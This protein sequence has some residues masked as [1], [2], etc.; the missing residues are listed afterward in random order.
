MTTTFAERL[1]HAMNE[2]H[3]SQSEL[4]SKTGISKASIS[5][6]LSGKNQ[7][8]EEKILLMADVLKA[9]PDFLMGKDVPPMLPHISVDKIG[10]R[11]AARCLGKSEQFIRIGLQRGI[12]PFGNA[13]PG[14]GKH[15]NYYINPAKF[16]DY[17]GTERFNDFFGLTA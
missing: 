4:S 8:K 2:A 6:Y 12:L 16:R 7:P 17:V 9:S 10:T 1:K 3:M 11:T 5:Q 14:I 15:W 13:V